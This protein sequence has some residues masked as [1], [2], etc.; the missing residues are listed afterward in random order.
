MNEPRDPLELELAAL[1]PHE[2]SPELQSRIARRLANESPAISPWRRIALAGGLA[3]A[4]VAAVLLWWT[5]GRSVE[6]DK[7]AIQ[8][9]PPAQPLNSADQGPTVL[10]YRRALSQSPE[11]LDALLDKHAALALPRNSE[12]EPF[13]AFTR[14]EVEL[15][16]LKG[17]L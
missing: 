10:A 2:I 14:S 4:G 12:A 6:P 15:R 17:E 11:A 13:Y 7:I 8:P 5:S 9:Q 3:A 16:A 1:R